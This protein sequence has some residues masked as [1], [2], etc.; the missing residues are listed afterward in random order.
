M[1][2][3]EIPGEGKEDPIQLYIGFRLIYQERDKPVLDN[4]LPPWTS[5]KQQYKKQEN[6]RS[7]Q[8]FC[9]YGQNS[10]SF[11]FKMVLVKNGFM[12]PLFGGVTT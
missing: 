4:A 1:F 10:Q 5:D 9:Q 11:N 6:N 12:P 7:H 8:K 2:Y 3:R